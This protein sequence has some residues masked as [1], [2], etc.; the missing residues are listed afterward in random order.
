MDG[1]D[2]EKRDRRRLDEAKYQK[3]IRLFASTFRV[4]GIPFEKNWLTER[5][6]I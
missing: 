6:D 2:W 3:V 5:P 1:K 4:K